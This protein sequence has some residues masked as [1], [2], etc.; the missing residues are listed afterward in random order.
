MDNQNFDAWY[1][2][3]YNGTYTV[4]Y[5]ALNTTYQGPLPFQMIRDEYIVT[6]EMDAKEDC[7][8]L[9]SL[10]TLATGLEKHSYK[11][12]DDVSYGFNGDWYYGGKI[13]RFTKSGKFFFTNSGQKFV[14]LTYNDELV[15]FM[16]D[17]LTVYPIKREYFQLVSSPF[18]AAKGIIK[19]WN[20][21]F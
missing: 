7:R 5:Y 10:E 1:R 15:V 3:N 16:G 8:L 4:I 17:K 11:V 21:H 14:R 18:T 6:S 2:N 20:P 9:N 13:T 12:G 19:E